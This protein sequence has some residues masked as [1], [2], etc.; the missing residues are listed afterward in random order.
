M[1]ERKRTFDENVL[2]R[3]SRQY[4][5]D[6]ALGVLIKELS[7]AKFKNGELLSEIAELKDQIEVLKHGS[8]NQVRKKKKEWLKDDVV[9]QLHEE[10]LELQEKLRQKSRQVDLWVGKYYSLKPQVTKLT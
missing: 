6:E 4:S 3:I 5:K 10:K 8:L 9:K 1:I 7:D 2:L